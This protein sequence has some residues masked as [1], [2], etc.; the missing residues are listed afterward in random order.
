MFG[1][2]YN[3][4]SS[5]PYQKGYGLGGTFRRL[6]KWIVPIFKK[7]ALPVLKSSA[8]VIGTEAISTIGD[9]SKDIIS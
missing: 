8:K 6:F 7:H 4:Y 9:I 3:T 1:R 2:G 5:L